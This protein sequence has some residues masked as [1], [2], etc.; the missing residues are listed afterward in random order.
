MEKALMV[1][2]QDFSVSL[3]PAAKGTI[4]HCLVVQLL[5]NPQGLQRLESAQF[6]VD[7]G[8]KQLHRASAVPAE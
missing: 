2:M 6:R 8:I 1:Q 7:T 5:N 3:A 4:H